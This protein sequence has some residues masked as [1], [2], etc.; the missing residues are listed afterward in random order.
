MFCVTI[1]IRYSFYHYTCS[2]ITFPDINLKAK[3]NS[4]TFLFSEFKLDDKAK[5]LIK[6][7]MSKYLD[8]A[9]SLNVRLLDYKCFG[10]S[11]C[12]PLN[13][14]PD[15]LMQLSFQVTNLKTV[16]HIIAGLSETK[17]AY[18]VAYSALISAKAVSAECDMQ[19]RSNLHSD[20]WGRALRRYYLP[21]GNPCGPGSVSSGFCQQIAESS[22][23]YGLSGGGGPPKINSGQLC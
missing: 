1:R 23:V 4:I 5:N 16:I 3:T 12:K 2:I 15:A 17:V 18:R 14:S 11:L 9:H 13:I 10:R 22:P 8:T 7:A 20:Q 21:S 19:M 6:D